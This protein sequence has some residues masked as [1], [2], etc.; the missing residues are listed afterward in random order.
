MCECERCA[1]RDDDVRWLAMLLRQAFLMVAKGIERRYE[2]GEK[3]RDE[4]RAA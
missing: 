1:R 4:R 2:L 3:P